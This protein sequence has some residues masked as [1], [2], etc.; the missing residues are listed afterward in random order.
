MHGQCSLSKF[1]RQTL[2]AASGTSISDVE[3]ASIVLHFCDSICQ[4]RIGAIC[5]CAKAS[6]VCAL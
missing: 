1:G 2:H 5:R 4:R 3:Q 6:R